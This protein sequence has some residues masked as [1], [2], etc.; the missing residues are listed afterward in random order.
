[1][2]MDELIATL[3]RDAEERCEALLDEARR[4]AERIRRDTDGQLERRSVS[5]ARTLE[6]ELNDRFAATMA[7]TR[8][9]IRGALLR[10]RRRALDR[11]FLRASELHLAV[12]EY[13]VFLTS[14][15]D[16]L[17]N[18]LSCLGAEEVEVSCPPAMGPPLREAADA[19]AAEDSSVPGRRIRVTEVEHAPA[20][21]VARGLA[22][23]VL[24]D[25]TVPTRIEGL[26]PELEMDVLR[27][28]DAD[29]P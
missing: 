16:A 14:L 19:V 25:L 5:A 1:M 28:I 17:R 29:Q 15:P 9:R 11:V 3:E 8:T 2:G 24:V 13:P 4:E 26:R 7:T 27:L 18:A 21:F 6:S 23:G 12:M 22:T 20:G 10:A